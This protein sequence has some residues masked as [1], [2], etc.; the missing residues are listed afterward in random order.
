MSYVYLG[1]AIVAEVIA[2]TALKSAEGF[3]RLWPS[4]VVLAGYGTAF[5]LLSLC[6]R[7]IPVGVVYAIWSA[8]GILL[9][10]L[11]AWMIHGQRLDLPAGLG[12]L[13]IVAGVVVIQLFSKTVGEHRTVAPA[14]ESR[15]EAQS[16]AT[17][18]QQ[19]GK[20]AS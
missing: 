13:L 4:L 8:V 15:S 9:V 2:T 20:P 3:T 19:T 12:M 5:Y 17:A 11:L 14:A 10:T 18:Q 7:T 6:M 16:P 1:I